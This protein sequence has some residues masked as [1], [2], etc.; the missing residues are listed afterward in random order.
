MAGSIFCSALYTTD[1]SQMVEYILSE[2]TDM[3]LPYP[4]T[5]DACLEARLECTQPICDVSHVYNA[6]QQVE[7]AM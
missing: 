3:H 2:L 7:T 6:L 5:K 4:Y 1:T